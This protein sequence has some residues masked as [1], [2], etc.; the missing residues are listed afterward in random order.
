MT[1]QS[2][3]QICFQA[4]YLHPLPPESV[5]CSSYLS[6]HLVVQPSPFISL[7]PPPSQTPCALDPLSEESFPWHYN[8]TFFLS[9]CFSAFLEFCFPFPHFSYLPFPTLIHPVLPC[10]SLHMP[11]CPCPSLPSP[12]FFY[13]AGFYSTAVANSTLQSFAQILFLFFSPSLLWYHSACSR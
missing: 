11:A 4:L 3:D 10:L 1:L 9:V 12:T 5:G 13:L 6:P 7:P 2:T 8:N